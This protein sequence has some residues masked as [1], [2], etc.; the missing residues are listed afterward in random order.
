M[1]SSSACRLYVRIPN[2]AEVT[3]DGST[4]VDPINYLN[5]VVDRDRTNVKD[6]TDEIATG[7]KL[8]TN[9]GMPIS[10]W[11]KRMSKFCSLSSDALLMEAMN[12]YWDMRRVPL[13]VD[14]HDTVTME[15]SQSVSM[16]PCVS[17]GNAS[18]LAVIPSEV[19][20]LVDVQL[21]VDAAIVHPS[22]PEVGAVSE[23]ANNVG[24]RKSKRCKKGKKVADEGPW[25]EDEVEYVGLND[26]HPYLSDVEEHSEN[27]VQFDGDY[28]QQDDLYV[29]D[30]A[31]CEIIEHMTDLE[32][33]TIGI[34]VTF[35]DGDTFK[36]A[37]RQYA[38]LHE[39]EIA[40]HYNES[41]RYRGVCKGK[42]SKTKNCR[43]RIHASELQDGKTWQVQTCF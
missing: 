25:D 21:D 10:F 14:V 35:E 38:V 12:L 7:M 5:L 43:W 28:D 22:G 3:D 27:E 13:Y 8:G 19:V 23:Q 30:E 33:P 15:Y 41:K 42:T 29:D 9:Q 4:T 6:I 31:G 40:A 11:N 36:R 32:N 20:H 2:Y 24:A 39:F 1:D 34:G 16:E 18:A 26:E 37:I 17:Q